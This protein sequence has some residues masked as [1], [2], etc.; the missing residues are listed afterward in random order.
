MVEN[1]NYPA[2]KNHVISGAHKEYADQIVIL[3]HGYK[4][5]AVEMMNSF[6]QQISF[7]VMRTVVISIEA[8]NAA[9]DSSVDNITTQY[10]WLRY[11]GDQ[12][13][14]AHVAEKMTMSAAK[15]VYEFILEQAKIYE[16]A[17][18][19]IYLVGYSQGAYLAA[20]VSAISSYQF[21][22]IIE[23]CGQA[24]SLD[25]ADKAIMKSPIFMINGEFDKI[26]PLEQVLARQELLRQ[27]GFE[28]YEIILYGQKHRITRQYVEHVISIII[29]QI[30]QEKT[31]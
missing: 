19:N 23:V 17:F 28:I 15:S 20:T 8:P 13:W 1:I 18:E 22:A 26:I 12:I 30:N 7:R 31:V 10:D 24:L 5:N 9:K 4:M 21:G 11:D 2:I 14:D 27:K 16:I 25:I 29:H 6:G 3:L